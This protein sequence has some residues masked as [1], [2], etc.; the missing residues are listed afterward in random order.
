MAP[1]L[2]IGKELAMGIYLSYLVIEGT[3]RCNMKCPHCLRGNAQRV[4]MDN[5]VANRITQQVDSVYCITFSGG[6]PSL[7]PDIIRNFQYGFM[8][9]DCSINSFW[10][11]TNAR[12][13]KNEFSD[14]L[15]NLYSLC[16]EK[17]ECRLTISGDQYHFRRSERATEEYS[18]LCFFSEERMRSIEEYMIVNEG[19]AKKN[20][21]GYRDI[22][23]MKKI[24]GYSYHGDDLYIDDT[25]YINALGDVLLN[26]DLSYRSQKK[27]AIGN[28]LKESLKDILYRNLERT[29]AE[30]YAL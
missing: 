23:P 16:Q 1:F 25:I 28:V 21:F 30:V 7:N 24:S 20:Q 11:T 17:D 6:E 10:V 15:E 26:S 29:D 5:E 3:R 2:H 13:Y 27:Y 19:M 4:D 9:N 14:A 8:F 12:F 22:K 18:Q